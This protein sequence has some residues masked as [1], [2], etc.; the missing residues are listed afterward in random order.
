VAFLD[1]AKG[2]LRSRYTF[3][4][5]GLVG[6]AA[7]LSTAYWL[8]WLGAI[9]G[10]WLWV[11]MSLLAGTG[12]FAGARWGIPW[13]RE[14]RFLRK[15]GSEYMVAG[16]ESP[17]EFRAK[18]AK[19]LQMLRS[20]PQLKGKA[21]PLY[22][23]P[24]Y[25]LIGDTQSGKTV[26]V[27]GAGVFSPLFTPSASSGGTQNYDWWVSNAAVILDTAGR[28]ALPVNVE[29][30][31]AEWY[32]LLRLLHHHREREPINGVVI[33]VGA[34]WLASQP[35]EKLRGEASKLRDRLE[36]AVRE[37]GI[38]FPVY[39]LVSKCD[40]IEGFGEF[41]AQLPERVRDEVL[42]FVDEHA[43]P[44]RDGGGALRGAAALDR[45]KAGLQSTFDRLHRFRLS[46]LDGGPPEAMRH[47]I[48]CFPEEF[49]TL[50]RPLMAF[51]EPLF[52]EDVRYHTPQ[53]R[54]VFFTS[55]MQ[56]PKRLSL[57]RRELNLGDEATALDASTRRHF[58]SDLFDT[59]LPRDRALVSA[60]AREQRRKGLS[61]F[62]RVGGSA[63]VVVLAVVLVAR[64]YIIDRRIAASVSPAACPE[65]A[66]QPA[67]GPRLE[68]V[69]RCLLAVQ[70]LNEQTRRRSRWATWLFNR[71]GRLEEGLRERYVHAFATELLAPLNTELDHSF[72]ASTDPLPLMLL[73][74]RRIQLS[75]RCLSPQGC[76]E[77][78]VDELQP[79]HPL[80]LHPRRELPAARDDAA[81]L[82][83][84]YAGYV[85]WQPSEKALLQ[86]D[87]ADDQKR[88]RQW[89]S[90][91][92]FSLDSLLPLVNKRSP[93]LTYDDYW[94]MP[95]PVTSITAPQIDAACTKQVW[96]QDVAPFL[97]QIQDA[98]PDAA[99][100]VRAFQQQYH[101]T[102]L[103]QWQRFLAGFARGAERWKGPEASRTL[104]LRLLSP[105]SPY[106]RVMDDAADNLAPWLPS[107]GDPEGV[108]AWAEELKQYAASDQ[109]KAY[110]GAL[111]RIGAPLER[112]ALPEA[113]FKLA[114]DTFGEGKP[115]AE[116]ATPVL[117]AWW[118]ASQQPRD[119]GD[120]RKRDES[121]LPALLEQP[122]HYVWRFILEEAGTHLQK[123]WAENVLAPL[124]GLPPAEQAVMMYGPGGKVAAFGEQFLKPFLKGEDAQA[125]TVLGEGVPFSPQFTQVL[126]NA[127]ELKTVLEGGGAS[128]PVVVTAS[129][130][131]EIEARASFLGEQTIFSVTCGGK[132]YRVTNRP[133]EPDESSTAVPWTSQGCGDATIT[134]YFF[135]GEGAPMQEDVPGA[136][137]FQLTKSYSGKTGFLQFLQ[138]FTAGAH[139]FR[140]DDLASTD[141]D[142]LRSGVD[143]V[144]VHYQIELPPGLA[145]LVSTLQETTPPED[146]V[147]PSS[148]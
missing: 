93:P 136:K 86:H 131:S 97:Q 98:V 132:A 28:Y 110:Q 60:T 63:A 143:A 31:R 43:A 11:I 38:D 81:T 22:V 75:R 87:L 99:A 78:T 62:M 111:A 91:K 18:F 12:V 52:S 130:R 56:G 9:V 103:I 109:R 104:A 3:L 145:K 112:G 80:M 54:A 36:E 105:E 128:Q 10:P 74:A 13:L 32:R 125:G 58:L 41:F 92:Q 134:V 139:R 126:A 89:L 115:T 33:A 129:G 118:I 114:Q 85:L 16:E 6:V 15:E 77:R 67:S 51:A 144:T 48:F 148:S 50:Q 123:A 102:C 76:S 120:P 2:L 42:G 96:Q 107:P 25:L 95:A 59:I 135:K 72:Q 119:G 35:D 133:Q 70:T 39:L 113:C 53:F 140:L 84:A 46:I 64:A 83:R 69:G 68:P 61:R 47:A 127:K 71:S 37:L 124:K 101:R 100:Q 26:A 27:Q 24:W 122:L 7:M 79:D 121:V 88:L 142:V 73:V 138:D 147:A 8:G 108:A 30:D 57:L 82:R 55:A 66:A 40:A 20:L 29:R 146:I 34:D 21:D 45:L 23:L 4:I 19:A 90:T 94:Q 1:T 17:E 141:P 116:S 49:R 106:A 117:R 65:A 137:R 5:A 44:P 14:R